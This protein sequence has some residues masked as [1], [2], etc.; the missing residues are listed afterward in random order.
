MFTL[1][2]INATYDSHTFSSMGYFHVGT[3]WVKKD[4]VSATTETFKPTKISIESTSLLLQDIN[5]LKTRIIVVE[6]GLESSKMWLKRTFTFRRTLV[7]MLESCVF[8][9]TPSKVELAP[10]TLNLSSLSTYPNPTFL[11]MLKDPI[12][13]SVGRYSAFLLWFS[14]VIAC[15]G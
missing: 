5:E 10:R 12:I 2:E 14:S 11:R 1:V 9:L 6:R 4:Y 3:K 13:P 15:S 8:K 7:Q